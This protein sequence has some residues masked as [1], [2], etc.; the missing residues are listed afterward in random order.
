MTKKKKRTKCEQNLL[1]NNIWKNWCLQKL[2]L[3]K[4]HQKILQKFLFPKID[5]NKVLS[6]YENDWQLS[7]NI[8]KFK[9]I[10]KKLVFSNNCPKRIKKYML[11]SVW[12]PVTVSTKLNVWFSVLCWMHAGKNWI[13]L[14]YPLHSSE[15]M[16]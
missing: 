5:V 1:K 3:K 13:R 6:K 2:K 9:V 7:H 8:S 4:S 15:W 10:I 16:I 12:T 14:R 11:T